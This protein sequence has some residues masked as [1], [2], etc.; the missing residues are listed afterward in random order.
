DNSSV[1]NSGDLTSDAFNL[2]IYVPY[3]DVQYL[4]NNTTFHDININAGTL[5]TGEL[6]LNQIGTNTSNLRYVFPG[7]FKVASGATLSVGANVSVLIQGG[8][9]INDS[10]TLTFATG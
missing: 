7:G 3:N 10:G 1:L 6:D 8:Q 5:P 9:T 4:G 2:P